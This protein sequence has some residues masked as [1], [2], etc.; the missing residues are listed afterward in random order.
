MI[1][2]ISFIANNEITATPLDANVFF[3]FRDRLFVDSV[4]GWFVGNSSPCC[5]LPDYIYFLYLQRTRVESHEHTCEQD[6]FT[7]EAQI[8]LGCGNDIES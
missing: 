6:G 2:A 1:N 4:E 8:V 5:L 3:F 7:F